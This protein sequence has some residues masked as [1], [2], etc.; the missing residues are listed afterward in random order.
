MILT[1]IY[2]NYWHIFMMTITIYPKACNVDSVFIFFVYR[3]SDSMVLSG[4]YKSKTSLTLLT[5][6][7]TLSRP[8]SLTNCWLQKNEF[9]L[10]LIP[11]LHLKLK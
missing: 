9:I 3:F 11:V 5:N 7:T 4:L 2:Y 1:Y 10:S 6:S 8:T